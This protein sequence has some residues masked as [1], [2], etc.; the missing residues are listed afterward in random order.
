[1]GFAVIFTKMMQYLISPSIDTWQQLPTMLRPTD[2]QMRTSHDI[3][4]N[5]APS[6]KLRDCLVEKPT[7]WLLVWLKNHCGMN[8]AGKWGDV[9]TVELTEVGNWKPCLPMEATH[10]DNSSGIE[11]L[12][13]IECD[14]NTGRR[15]I[16]HEFQMWCWDHR[17]WYISREVLKVWPDLFG[18]IPII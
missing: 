16:S 2:S 17:N 11:A 4:V 14:S 13:A 12:R 7:D 1:M 9:G 3:S 8:W 10:A 18:E 15:H 6:P 5:F